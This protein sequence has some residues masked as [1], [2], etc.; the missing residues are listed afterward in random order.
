MTDTKLVAKTFSGL[1]DVLAAELN[2]LEASAVQP[3]RRMVEF[4]GTKEL[5]YRANL[6]L[7]TALRVLKP[8][9][10]FQASND[11]AFYKKVRALD[12]SRWLNPDA[13]FAVDAV[14]HSSF[15]T[16]SKYLGLR[17]KDAI[18]DQFR[19]RFGRR[20]SVDTRHPDIRLNVY[21]FKNH[22]TL[23][24]DSSGE[25]LHRRG[26]RLDSNPA[27]LNEVLAA[28]MVQLAGWDGRGNFLDPLCGSGTLVIEA[29]L[30][31]L[32]IPPG[33]NRQFGFMNWP[34]FDSALW[35]RILG[36]ASVQERKTDVRIVGSDVSEAA[37]RAARE[38]ARRAGVEEAIPFIVSP[39]EEIQPPAGGGILVTNPPYNERLKLEDAREFYRKLG[40]FFKQKCAGYTAWVLSANQA[41]LKSVGLRPTRTLTLYNGGLKSRF[42]Q[43]DLYAGSRK[44]KKSG[45]KK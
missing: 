10:S 4:S 16:H 14:V 18:V 43:F 29:A 11:S 24:L 12:W 37:I 34:D 27:P 44:G 15:L 19:D 36:E 17:T 28:G 8:I 32:N 30:L 33:R 5:L 20:P 25:S 39:F 1:E 40:D 41:G 9:A 23:A 35:R 2:A 22:C 7:R 13:T 21:L 26:Y 3:G 38:N 42:V 6:H 45:R 31:A